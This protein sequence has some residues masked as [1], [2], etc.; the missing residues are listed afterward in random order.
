MQVLYTNADQFLN[1]RDELCM[2][3][4]G[5]EP[6]IIMVTE[7][8]PK[9]QT[10]PIADSLL[11]VPGYSL[12]TN[13]DPSLSNLGASGCRGVSIYLRDNLKATEVSFGTTT[14]IEQVWMKLPLM[15]NDMLLVG[16]IYRS[17]T[18]SMLESSAELCQLLHTACASAPSHLLIGGDFNM[19]HIDW[20]N[21]FSAAPPRD[22]SHQFLEML[23]D[24]F[25]TQQVNQPTRFRPGETPH[26]LDLILTNEDGMVNHLF[27]EAGLGK[28]DHVILRFELAC[29]TYQHEFSSGHPNYFKGNPDK[30]TRLVQE[31]DWESTEGLSVGEKYD[32]MTSHLNRIALE[33]FPKSKRKG[34]RKN[35]YINGQALRL[36]KK[37][38][39]LWRIYSLSQDMLDYCRYTQCRN[40]LRALTR[41]LRRDLEE[42]LARNVKSN[43]KA[44]WRYSNTRLRT[45]AKL[46]D[47]VDD[48]GRTVSDDTG[49]AKLLNAFFSSIFTDEDTAEIPE[50]TT[51]FTGIPI[52]TMN[53]TTEAVNNKLSSLK[54]DSTPGPDGL[55][56]KLLQ[57]ASQNLAGPLASLFRA[58]LDQ[59]ILP[60]TWKTAMVVPVHKKGSKQTPGNY[61]PISLTSIPCKIMESLI[62]DE[63]MEFLSLTGQL[64]RHQHG[65]RPRR[66]CSSQLLEVLED[67]CKIIEQGDSVD[68]VYL[69]FRKAF[70]AV[71]HNR[72]LRKLHGYG[73]AGKLLRWIEAFLSGRKQKVVVNGSHSDLVPVKSGVPQGSVLGPLLFLLYV[74][75]IPSVVDCTAKMFA[76]DTKVYS[77]VSMQSNTDAQAEAAVGLAVAQSRAVSDHSTRP[78]QP[79]DGGQDQDQYG[80]ES[81]A[82]TTGVVGLAVVQ[83]RAVRDHSTRPTQPVN[84]SQNQTGE[85]T[86]AEATGTVGLAV[87]QSRA[88]S[89]HPTRPQ[90]SQPAD[91]AATSTG[92]TTLQADIDALVA[93]S[94]RWQLP[95]NEGKCKILHLGTSN[96]KLRYTMRGTYLEETESERDLGVI[97][98]ASLKFR[99][100]A[101]AAVAKANQIL[102]VIRRS[103]ELI[104]EFTLPLLYKTL[105]RPHLEF[106]NVAWG[107]FNRADQ[108]LVER[109]QRRA[110]R[111]VA[112]LRHRPYEERLE[113]L[114]LPSLF[115]R[116]RRGDM[117]QV[118]QIFHGGV[119]LAPEEFFTATASDRTRGHPWKLKKPRAES[120]P[121]RQA[122]SARVVNDWNGLPPSVVGAGSVEQFKSELDAHWANIRY[123]VP[124][125]R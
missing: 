57:L 91:G 86:Q 77:S 18:S 105:V 89:D 32:Y 104:D 121:R 118:Y 73:V 41:R 4:A 79:V 76:D 8:I 56:P 107:P 6:D 17:P 95:F 68:V 122:F 47:L 50:P 103:F 44:F 29:Y 108:L 75:D 14:H 12:H 87:A 114:K 9:A 1:K 71:P 97:V 55:H 70:D 59:G 34:S 60:E 16:C 37:K 74:N 80:D 101:A 65:F 48:S 88:G 116:R 7:V 123:L 111:L 102:A 27:H 5:N 112:S 92:A 40:Q 24:C 106:G 83:S 13:F 96:P 25:L 63:L 90:A 100:Q 20:E 124:D 33:C 72:L 84:G 94:D 43:P 98:D 64:S 120:R 19:P 11:A 109:V 115:Y 35:I 99:R 110:T 62:R 113:A 52:E 81:Q 2:K 67:W 3:I 30:F 58:S 49:K 42:K 38:E 46:D 15:G 26:I 85:E 53:I 21:G 10:V 69:D 22:I 51:Q 119:D 54:T 36:K 125:W 61:R 66:S 78:T 82:E 117:V 93:W 31:L 23:K 39:K 45:K 28:S